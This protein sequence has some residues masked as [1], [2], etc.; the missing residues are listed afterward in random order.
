M[1]LNA[2]V[3]ILWKERHTNKMDG[4]KTGQVRQKTL[5]PTE[6]GDIYRTRTDRAASLEKATIHLT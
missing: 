5:T 4:W 1:D 6:K 2:R 3:D